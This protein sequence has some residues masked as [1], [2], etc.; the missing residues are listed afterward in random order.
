MIKKGISFQPKKKKKKKERNKLTNE[1]SLRL[2][3]DNKL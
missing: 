1:L 2:S 3:Q